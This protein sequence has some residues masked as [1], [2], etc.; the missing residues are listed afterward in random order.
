MSRRSRAAAVL[1]ALAIAGVACTGAIAAGDASAQSATPAPSAAVASEPVGGPLLHGTGVIVRPR[2]GATKLPTVAV[3]SYLVADLSTGAVLAAK[4]PHQRNRPASTL[5][6]LTGL[7]LLP[8]LDRTAKYTATYQD[9]A[10]IGSAVG[11]VEGHTY[12][13]DQLFLG[14]FLVSGNDAAH[15][16]ATAAG[17]EKQTVMLMQ[18]TAAHLRALDTTVVNSSGLDSDREY[19]S[20]YD[21]AL[22]ARAGLKRADFRRYVSTKQSRFPAKEKGK[23]FAISNQNELLGDYPGAIG[24]KTG[25]TSLAKNTLVAAATRDDRTILVVLMR[26]RYGIH[27]EA[28]RLLNWGFANAESVNAVGRLVDPAPPGG[29]PTRSADTKAAVGP[30]APHASRE[31]DLLDRLRT[32]LE[33]AP[34]RDLVAAG[35]VAFIA[36]V[37]LLGL[38]RRRR[39]RR[40]VDAELAHWAAI[41]A[42]PE[43]A[44]AVDPSAHPVGGRDRPDRFGR[45]GNLPLYSDDAAY[46]GP[47][48]D[49]HPAGP[50]HQPAGPMGTAPLQGP[51]LRSVDPL[52]TASFQSRPPRPGH[53]LGP[54]RHP[55]GPLPPHTPGPLA[56]PPYQADPADPYWPG[57]DARPM[58]HPHAQP[59]TPRGDDRSRTRRMP[60]IAPPSPPTGLPLPSQPATTAGPP[61]PTQPLPPAPERPLW[62][63]PVRPARTTPP[64]YPQIPVNQEGSPP[65]DRYR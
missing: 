48:A 49:P 34:P 24:V 27:E 62:R 29:E 6:I 40:S 20:A 5:K 37:A 51:P 14:L 53:P 23:T 64:H 11:I 45:T 55:S 32:R 54:P 22:I 60:P 15:A 43:P 10:Q 35:G 2:P 16:L 12:T 65:P 30:A 4:A 52:R 9:D 8:R 13:I 47:P 1:L 28:A 19:S 38:W 57:P 3:R 42:Q 46:L 26:G 31:P 21:L 36:C 17:G 41:Q 59:N 7:T 33:E 56:P 25:Y 61:L 39:R 18:R 44:Y 58:P 63:R 50:P